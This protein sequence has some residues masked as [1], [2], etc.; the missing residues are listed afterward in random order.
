MRVVIFAFCKEVFRR[1][2]CTVGLP[3]RSAS[4]VQKPSVNWWTRQGLFYGKMTWQ[5]R[6]TILGGSYDLWWSPSVE[7]IQREI[8]Y[9]GPVLAF[10]S[11]YEDFFCYK[12]GAIAKT[13]CYCKYNTK[14]AIFCRH[15]PISLGQIERLPFDET[16]RLGHQRRSGLLASGEHLGHRLGWKR[17]IQ[18]PSRRQYGRHWRTDY[19]RFSEGSYA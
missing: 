8:F 1:I 16:D 6:I 9:Y 19:H 12:T 11:V 2:V 14:M 15:I 7:K 3:Q 18:N 13:A 4:A 5:A 17:Y 10:F